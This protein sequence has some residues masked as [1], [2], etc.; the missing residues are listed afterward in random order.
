[1][2]ENQKFG[3]IAICAAVL[4]LV[5]LILPLVTSRLFVPA[6][7]G[8]PEINRTQHFTMFGIFGESGNVWWTMTGLF[9]ILLLVVVA[10]LVAEGVFLLM[11]KNSSEILKRNRYIMCT[12]GGLAIATAFFA[13]IA[14]ITTEN[15]AFEVTATGAEVNVTPG[16]GTYIL[17]VV[18]LLAIAHTFFV[19]PAQYTVRWVG[20]SNQPRPQPT[21]A[22]P[23][24]KPEPTIQPRPVKTYEPIQETPPPPPAPAVEE[25]A[26]NQSPWG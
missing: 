22:S 20:G 23:A 17:A 24:P 12:V 3:I 8:Q 11:D 26:W 15:L 18:G 16:F 4:I 21:Y 7:M 14:G 19:K 10:G 5:P 9:S 13:I 6:L 25:P 2:K 1:M